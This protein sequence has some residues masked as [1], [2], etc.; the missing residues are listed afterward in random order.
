MVNDKRTILIAVIVV[1]LVIAGFL[2]WKYKFSKTAT[3]SQIPAISSVDVGK[4]ISNKIVNP[5][6]PQTNPFSAK[7]NPFTGVYKN[8]FSK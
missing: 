1:V 3:S 8:P 2:L 7:T 5:T 4:D 6:L